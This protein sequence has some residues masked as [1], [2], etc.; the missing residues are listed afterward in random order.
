MILLLFSL[1]VPKRV[2]RRLIIV[3]YLHSRS[4]R[5]SWSF[6]ITHY[7]IPAHLSSQM[8]NCFS[9]FEPDFPTLYLCYR[10]RYASHFQFSL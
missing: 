7:V 5:C 4:R 1:E 2:K 9:C 6:K 8:L 3:F 10:N